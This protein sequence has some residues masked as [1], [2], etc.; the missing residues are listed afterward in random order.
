MLEKQCIY[1]SYLGRTFLFDRLLL[2]YVMIP[3]MQREVNTFVDVVWNCHRIREQR[4]T[5]LPDGVPNH[6]YSFPDKY[7]LE[8]C[9][10][11][12]CNFFT[13]VLLL[14]SV[15]IPSKNWHKS[16]RDPRVKYGQSREKVWQLTNGV[17]QS[18][19]QT[20]LENSSHVQ[21]LCDSSQAPWKWLWIWKVELQNSFLFQIYGVSAVH[22]KLLKNPALTTTIELIGNALYF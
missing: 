16:S 13:R 7:G 6:I 18:E 8:D 19:S 5:F 17:N 3:I 21:W 20:S 11:Y 12:L 2:A 4:D 22:D 1:K 9:G 14:I 15:R 10:R